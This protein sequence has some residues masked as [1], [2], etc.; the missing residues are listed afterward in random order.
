MS[1]MVPEPTG[2]LVYQG[3]H[4]K[5]FKNMGPNSVRDYNEFQDE[6][7]KNYPT[8]HEM[9]SLSADGVHHKPYSIKNFISVELASND[10][11]TQM[12]FKLSPSLKR[13]FQ[14]SSSHRALDSTAVD[15]ASKQ[16]SRKEVTI[17]DIAVEELL[18]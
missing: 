12:E 8:E 14:R 15:S 18:Q 11:N 5:Y 6:Q 13:S 10:A 4:E 7:I 3:S 9:D 16:D 1:E 17:D 2:I